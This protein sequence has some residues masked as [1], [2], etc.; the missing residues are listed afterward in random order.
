MH[1]HAGMDNLF[2]L[3][4]YHGSHFVNILCGYEGGVKTVFDK[5]DLEKWSKIEIDSMVRIWD[6]LLS[7]GFG[8]GSLV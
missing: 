2:S 1:L 6:M 7:V 5:C 3:V 4:L 8:I